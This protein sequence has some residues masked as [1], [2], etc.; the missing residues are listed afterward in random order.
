VSHVKRRSQGG[1]AP[2]MGTGGK[3]VPKVAR[4]GKIMQKHGGKVGN[5]VPGMLKDKKRGGLLG[6]WQK[7]F[8]KRKKGSSKSKKR[9][10][11][12]TTKR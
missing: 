10:A 5:K 7:K 12:L 2:S 4:Q 6:W 8:L 3:G 9:K 11:G 1:K